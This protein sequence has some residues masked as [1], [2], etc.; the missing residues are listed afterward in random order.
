MN[1]LMDIGRNAFRALPSPAQ[2]LLESSKIRFAQWRAERNEFRA[3]VDAAKQY[4][5]TIEDEVFPLIDNIVIPNNNRTCY[6]EA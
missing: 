2:G 4:Q 5:R 6:A 3:R 1:V